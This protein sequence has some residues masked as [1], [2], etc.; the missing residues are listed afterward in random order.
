MSWT[1]DDKSSTSEASL[2]E[3]AG[4]RRG[5]PV[6]EQP[7]VRR[8][9]PGLGLAGDPRRREEEKAV[10]C[11]RW[12]RGRANKKRSLRRLSSLSD[13]VLSMDTVVAGGSGA[14]GEEEEEPLT[15]QS[16]GKDRK[17]LLGGSEPG[18]VDLA[19]RHLPSSAPSGGWSRSTHSRDAQ[20]CPPGA[21]V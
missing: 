19:G 12:G 2:G 8:Q 15:E 21:H 7:Q 3:E 6:D 1:A 18:G 14:S 16:E 9:Q 13:T 11:W 17:I 10:W 5:H 4:G 20:A